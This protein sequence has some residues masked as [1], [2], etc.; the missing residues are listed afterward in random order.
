LYSLFNSIETGYASI[1][2]L[3]QQHMIN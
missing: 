2:D 3:A 1:Q